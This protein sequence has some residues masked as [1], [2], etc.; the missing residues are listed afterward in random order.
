MKLYCFPFAGGNANSYK[1]LASHLPKSIDF[2]PLEPPGRGHRF[3]EPLLTALPAMVDDLFPK[4]DLTKPYLFFGHSMGA[5]LAYLLTRRIA[6]KKGPLPKQLFVSGRQAPQCAPVRGKVKH[7]MPHDEFVRM[8]SDLGGCPPRLLQDRELL[9]LIEPVLRADFKAVETFVY[10]PF[11][12]PL[13]CPVTVL[14]GDCDDELTCEDVRPWQNE[15]RYP[16]RMKLFTGNHFFIF[17]H[18]PAIASLIAEQQSLHQQETD[19]AKD[20][21]LRV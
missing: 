8:L 1:D 12:T 15:T 5:T 10:A 3:G 16:L 21:P 13:D 2:H 18:W 20:I 6:E 9:E 17:N 11:S 4:L 14:R 19:R 7:R